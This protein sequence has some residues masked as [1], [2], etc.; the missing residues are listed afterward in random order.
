MK[1]NRG[2]T[3][4]EIMVVLAIMAVLTSMIGISISLITGQRLKSAV[5]D[6]KSLMQ[7][8]QTVAMSKKNC[9]VRF[10]QNSEGECVVTSISDANK[11]LKAVAINSKISV[12]I[13]TVDDN[14]YTINSSQSI[15]ITYVRETGGFGA[16]KLY[17]AGGTNVATIGTPKEISFTQ[18][19][20]TITLTL[21][22]YTGKISTK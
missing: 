6:T 10:E 2:V 22:T 20:R 9:V 16:C 18:G 11:Q 15:E 19:S 12:V 4:V 21:A 7:S 17:T 13:R 8:A 5:S 1:D 3:L 14:E